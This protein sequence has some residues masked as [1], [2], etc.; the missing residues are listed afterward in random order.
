MLRSFSCL[1]SLPSSASQPLRNYGS[2][3]ASLRNYAKNG[4]FRSTI[5]KSNTI[6]RNCKG[7]HTGTN[8]TKQS[9][10][11]WFPGGKVTILT[12]PPGSLRSY[13][14]KVTETASHIQ[15]L[16]NTPRPKT[17]EIRKLFSFAKPEKWRIAGKLRYGI[18][19]SFDHLFLPY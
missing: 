14:N 13:S 1:R 15:A 18:W 3:G 19:I 7:F 16:K 8:S 11:S 6:Q 12:K 10:I 4:L 5:S 17:S 2:L 9:R